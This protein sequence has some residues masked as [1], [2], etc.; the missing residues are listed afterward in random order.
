MSSHRILL[1]VLV[2]ATMSASSSAQSAEE[3]LRRQTISVTTPPHRTPSHCSVDAL[4]MG[5]GY[6]GVALSG[7][8]ERLVF[9]MARNDFWRLRSVHNESYPL[10]LGRLTVEL[11]SMAGAS[12]SASQDLWDATTTVRLDRTASSVTCQAYVA[13][14]D[15]VMVL[16]L[17]AE[18][19]E[20][21]EGRVVLSLPDENDI[22]VRF[23]EERQFPDM[24]QQGQTAGGIRYIE[25]AFVDSVD[26]ATHAAVALRLPKGNDGRFTL[27]P[28]KTLMLV[29]AFSSN[30]KSAD[31]LADAIARAASCSPRRLFKAHC[32][33]WHQYWERSYVSIPDPVVERQ[34]YL[35]LYGM[36]SCS[37]DLRFP[38][39]LFGTWI[40]RERPD[41]SGDY[42]LNYN[43][44]A[45]YYALYSADRIEQARPYYGPLLDFMDRGRYYSQQVTGIADGIMLPV[46][47]GPLGIET[48][49]CTPQFLRFHPDWLSGGN[50]ESEGLFW[51]QK[52]NA[53]Y[54]VV[55]LA[56]QFYH[57]WDI[58]FARE[59]Y[60][61]VRSVAIFWEHY[62]KRD[63]QRYII[64]NDAI[65][66]GTVGTMNP[67]LS[68]GLVR[69]VMTLALDMSSLLDCDADRRSAWLDR[70]DHLAD[71]PTQQ[72]DGQTVFRYTERGT[73]WWAD[74]T[75]GIQHIYPAGQ[76]GLESPDSLLAVARNTIRAMGRWM[77][78]N[79]T[80]SFY[81]AAVRVGLPGSEILRHLH[82][83]SLH[84]YPNGFQKDNPHGTE[85]WS[86]V[87]GTVNMMLCTGHQD[88]VR[89]FHVWPRSCDAMF[90][91]IR[92]EG[93]FLVSAR[94]A[95]GVVADVV[96]QSEQ[97][98]PLTLE[99]PWP[100]CDVEVTCGRERIVLHGER[101]HMPTR[102]G[103]TYRLRPIALPS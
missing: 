86:T 71:Y 67:I 79:G 47:I 56:M 82:E 24:R 41:W 8:P 62:L 48:T 33:W 42:H 59:V 54:A 51:G 101:L 45:P 83:Y 55:N 29:C 34:Y 11:P 38:P 22:E 7:G 6:T 84:T 37:R 23:A 102:R 18:G 76:I 31:C 20:T 30:F 57:T 21:V 26:I 52:S 25:R 3:I 35:S 103:A 85:N 100:G 13:A 63:G 5:N 61:I 9:H 91:H 77:D 1:L 28:G 16:R 92:V 53:A 43:H 58:Q 81:P 70:R 44:M 69:M 10:V 97:G 14:N 98:R 36:G 87:P 12:Y 73:A 50:V 99:N 74:N 66:E 93:A 19:T 39:P 90:H 72:R 75:L 88:V 64:L 4:L 89:L 78:F 49:R 40:T 68:L 46:G 96:I 17:S 80:N 94:L 60:P 27:A 32:R 65:H 15:D 95:K 2:L